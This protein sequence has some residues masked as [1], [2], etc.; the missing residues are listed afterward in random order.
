MIDFFLYLTSLIA[1]ISPS[2]GAQQEV[3]LIPNGRNITVTSKNKHR[4]V[5]CVAKYY[6]HDRIQK[7]AAA[8]F[9]GLY[10]VIQ[11]ELLGMF[12][13][14]ELQILISGAVVYP[15]PAEMIAIEMIL[16]LLTIGWATAPEPEDRLTFGELV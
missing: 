9:H 8:F 15:E 2:Q 14:P 3:D 12:C 7:Q 11:P 16:P 4:Y 13:A 5:Q 6:L 10:G 1:L